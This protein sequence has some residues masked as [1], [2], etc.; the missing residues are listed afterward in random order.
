MTFVNSWKTRLKFFM[1]LDFQSFLGFWYWCF[2]AFPYVLLTL[3]DFS[4]YYLC[5]HLSWW[6][7]RFLFNCIT[8]I[9]ANRS[10]QKLLYLTTTKSSWRKDSMSVRNHASFSYFDIFFACTY[11]VSQQVLARPTGQS[12]EDGVW[13]YGWGVHRWPYHICMVSIWNH[14]LSWYLFKS[15]IIVSA[16]TIIW[17]SKYQLTEWTNNL[18]CFGSW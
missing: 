4:S 8:C 9:N 16:Q 10:F 3:E 1:T 14:W 11:R 7:S 18:D 5:C 6:C 2:L 15:K 13:W 12:W 17:F